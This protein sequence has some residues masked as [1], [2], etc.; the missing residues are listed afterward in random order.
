VRHQP[1]MGAP[2]R[3]ADVRSARLVTRFRVLA[4]LGGF[5]TASALAARFSLAR[6]LSH[7]AAVDHATLADM[8]R[9][10]IGVP[11]PA[12]RLGSSTGR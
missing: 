10:R 4:S 12:G 7:S 8:K 5:Q 3:V 1:G 6:A 9:H 11:Q 2:R